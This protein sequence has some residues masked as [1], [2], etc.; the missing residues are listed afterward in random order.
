VKILD[1]LVTGRGVDKAL[2]KLR[3]D[4]EELML[5]ERGGEPGTA[6]PI[7]YSRPARPD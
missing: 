6:S 3:N 7:Y 4:L 2:Y 1:Q 5:K